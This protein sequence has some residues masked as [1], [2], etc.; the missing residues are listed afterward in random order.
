MTSEAIELA[1][2]EK[3]VVRYLVAL[4][5]VSFVSGFVLLVFLPAD[6]SFATVVTNHPL[7]SFFIEALIGFAGSAVA[8]LTSCINRYAAGLE[9]DD[10]TK[11]PKEAKGETFNRRMGRAFYT[12]PFLGFVAGP[13]L[14]WGLEL[15]AKNPEAF[16]SSRERLAFT[17]FMGGLLAKS[18]FDVIKNI[19]K[20]IFKT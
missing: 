12:R 13:V 16:V 14:I 7:G 9:L 18:V 15:F 17:A 5:L 8:A 4:L 10:G 20:N 11:E 3:D 1:A 19:F 6:H 2:L